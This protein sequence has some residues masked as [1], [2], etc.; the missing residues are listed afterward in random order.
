MVLLEIEVLIPFFYCTKKDKMS[1]VMK[2]IIFNIYRFILYLR[3]FLGTMFG[4][5]RD[6][7]Y[8]VKL[9]GGGNG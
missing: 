3:R 7:S 8:I 5:R 9:R 4:K 6:K 1:N 2:D